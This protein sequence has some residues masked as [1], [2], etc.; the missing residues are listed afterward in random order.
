MKK[1]IRSS[2]SIVLCFIMLCV[3]LFNNAFASSESSG[4]CGKNV[5]WSYSKSTNTL[6]ISGKGAMYNYDSMNDKTAPWIDCIDD[7]QEVTIIVRKG[8]T[9][10]GNEA[11][12]GVDIKKIS[13]PNTLTKIGN[14]SITSGLDTGYDMASSVTIPKSVKSIGKWA[15]VGGRGLKRI[16]VEKGNKYFVSVNGILFNK[17][18]KKLISC[19]SDKTGSFSIPSQT[20]TIDEY[21]FYGSRLN[22]L[23]IPKTVKTLKGLSF[24]WAS[25]D[26]LYFKGKPPKGFL[27][28]FDSETTEV[29]IGTIYYP[30][31]EES[32]W[33]KVIKKAGLDGQCKSWK[34]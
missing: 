12:N 22:K 5:K 10:I 25:M 28:V 18:K 13:L 32:S 24:E 27:D 33:K 20:T 16:K 30:K 2:L 23:V 11:F 29:E 21:A 9:T 19:P 14:Q 15:L 4:K 7:E 31:S 8:V 26:S 34:G 3:L 6:I 17:S 1:T